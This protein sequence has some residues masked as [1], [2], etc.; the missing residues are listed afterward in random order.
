MGWQQQRQ[1]GK[2]AGEVVV[3]QVPSTETAVLGLSY[4]LELEAAAGGQWGGKT[5]VAK[6]RGEEEEEAHEEA[7]GQTD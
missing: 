5:T 7:D 1:G 4:R 2:G 6:V 3:L